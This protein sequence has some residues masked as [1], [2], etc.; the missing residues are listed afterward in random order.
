MPP[1]PH[2]DL[3]TDLAAVREL[4]KDV[5]FELGATL[6]MEARQQATALDI[7]R[8]ASALMAAVAEIVPPVV[9]TDKE[10]NRKRR[11]A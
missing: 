6:G 10:L 1:S 5:A 7:V 3:L 8:R 9:A 4:L 11:V 2:A